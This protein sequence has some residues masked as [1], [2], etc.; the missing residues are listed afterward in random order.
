MSVALYPGAFKPPHK[1][2]FQVVKS[3]L[4]GSYNGKAYDIDD[5]VKVGDEILQNKIDGKPKIDKVIVFP[6]GGERNGITKEESIRIWQIYAKYLPGLEVLDGE[7]NPMFA[8]K[9][10]AKA[11]SKVNFYGVTG[12]RGGE[13]VVD[14]KRVTTYKNTPNVKGLAISNPGFMQ[15]ASE[16]RKIALTGN[17]DDLRDYFPSQLKREELFDI[18]SMLKDSIV[19]E[20]MFNT[21]DSFI[22]EWLD[23]IG[24]TRLTEAS[25][26][27]AIQ[28][29][30]AL[31]SE[32]RAKL[33]ILYNY[34]FNLTSRLYHTIE[35]KGDKVQVGLKDLEDQKTPYLPYIGSLLEY[36]L[37]QKMAITPLPEVKLRRDISEASNFFGKTAYYN[38][39]N[40]E[41]VLF[42]EGRHPKD[43]V[44]SFSHE[45]IHHMQNLDG[46]LGN[47]GTSDTNKDNNLLELEK[48]AYLMGNIT[49][50]NWEDQ[51]K[52]EN[53]DLVSEIISKPVDTNI[54]EIAQDYFGLKDFVSEVAK[55]II[56]EGKYDKLVTFLTNKSIGGIKN[57]LIKKMHV[58]K[59]K[60][61]GDPNTEDARVAMKKTVE[62]LY[63]IMLMSIPEDIYQ[64]FQKETDLEF[65]YDLKVMFVKG[66]N[67]IMRDGGAY[68][69]G[70]DDNDK[71]ET[72]KIE[73]EFVL[74]PYNFPRDFEELSGQISDVLRHEIEH[75]TQTGGNERGKTFG[76]DAMFGGKFGTDDEMKFRTKIARGVVKNGVSYLTLP[77]E[78]D[79]NIQ[80]LYLTAK[81]QRR[82]FKDVVDQYLY[83]FT[84]QFDSEGKPYLTKQDVEDVKK[85]WAL[86][87][88]ALGIKQRL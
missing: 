82:D 78:I 68:K 60:H 69:G 42:V 7:K 67:S 24:D 14:L 88:P 74:D 87:L 32:D 52:N 17:L 71:Y 27:T 76:K 40:N 83:Q 59:E 21:M 61:F 63:P 43:V 36:M 44:R 25:S 9:D 18:V 75:L 64:K 57:A 23:N 51:I 38:P 30:S 10:Y 15:R 81:K 53:K 12:I 1:G 84:D 11:N 73:L 35:L 8:A 28:P 33:V 85:V 4:D 79:A 66:I 13:D 50:R 6:G 62:E 56:N 47:I 26:G 5:Y 49:F 41:I 54:K 80:G 34:L 3:L 86:R 55:G 48:E 72:P 39:A 29:Q 45:M 2:H 20:K 65:D 22:N 46:R 19:S 16:L 31:R 58:Y 77:S 37:D 70:F